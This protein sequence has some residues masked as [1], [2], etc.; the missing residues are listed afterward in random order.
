MISKD[1]NNTMN[2]G[3]R[4]PAWFSSWLPKG[5][6]ISEKEVGVWTDELL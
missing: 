2:A 1:F 6:F 5:H 3:D 4:N